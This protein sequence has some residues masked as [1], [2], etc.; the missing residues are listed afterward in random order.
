[1]N[2]LSNIIVQ[3]SILI[4]LG[5]ISGGLLGA[6]IAV[7]LWWLSSRSNT[8]RELLLEANNIQSLK[9]A[10]I[11][12]GYNYK[13]ITLSNKKDLSTSPG[14][15]LY[16]KK[17]E[18]RAVLDDAKW[19]SPHNYEDYYYRIINNRRTWIVRNFIKEE[20][21]NKTFDFHPALISSRGLE[22][23]CAWIE[24]VVDAKWRLYFHGFKMLRPL[25]NAIAR[26]DR[27]EVFKTQNRLT[28]KAINFLKKI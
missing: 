10:W 5:A 25:L 18:V 1:M 17:V 24:R 2:I 8:R 21:K 22:E 12:V 3:N 9:E 6:I 14:S 4:L 13:N 23:L 19:N 11:L 28:D 26:S 20:D 27:I 16:L 15:T 7:I